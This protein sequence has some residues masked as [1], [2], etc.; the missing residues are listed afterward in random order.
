MINRVKNFYDRSASKVG[1]QIEGV[2]IYDIENIC[3][4]DENILIVALINIEAIFEYIKKLELYNL[5]YYL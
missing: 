5:H 1:G 4:V 3:D 2:P